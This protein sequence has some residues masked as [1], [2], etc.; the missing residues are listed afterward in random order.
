VP[1]GILK[2]AKECYPIRQPGSWQRQVKDTLSA[3]DHNRR[4]QL[5]R[6]LPKQPPHRPTA[7]W[8]PK[9]STTDGWWLG[10]TTVVISAPSVLTS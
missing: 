3:P 4:L 2:D 10:R 8:W 1:S 9:S 6:L 7:P 5:G